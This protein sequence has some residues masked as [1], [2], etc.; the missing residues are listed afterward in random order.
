MRRTVEESLSEADV[1]VLSG[2][3][4]VGTR[5]LTAKVINDIGKPGVLVHGVS[6]KPGKPTII[7]VVN[8]KP[9]FGLPGHP[10][11]VGVSYG[12][13]VKRVIRSLTGIAL[14]DLVFADRMVKAR[15]LKNIAS[16]S[17]REDYIRVEIR[18][19][20]GELTALPILGKS[21]LIST[22]VK[23]TGYIVIPEN[24]LGIEAGEIVEVYLYD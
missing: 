11:A 22:L 14:K 20:D 19:E 2:G 21:G 6:I 10:V 13:F 23:A 17:G 8:K 18:N 1:V 12:L 9:V 4:S 5:D 16:T 15:L 3:S 7:G 24:R